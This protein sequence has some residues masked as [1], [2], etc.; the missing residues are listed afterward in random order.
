MAGGIVE[1]SC[2]RCGKAMS[3]RAGEATHLCLSC[4]ETNAV[5]AGATAPS[6]ARPPVT[7][8]SA[9]TPLRLASLAGGLLLI[10]AAAGYLVTTMIGSEAPAAPNEMPATADQPAGPMPPLGA[11][12]V[13]VPIDEPL[14]TFVGNAVTAAAKSRLVK[15]NRISLA[16]FELNHMTKEADIAKEAIKKDEEDIAVLRSAAGASA[17]ILTAGLAGD[18]ASFRQHLG[19]LADTEFG[20]N[21]VAQQLL[22][23]LDSIAAG[24]QGGRVPEIKQMMTIWDE[25]ISSSR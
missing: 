4:G 7:Q 17:S 2:S 3:A 8:H 5:P 1:Y 16:D 10:A 13:R 22:R 15:Y 6:A 23:S 12:P 9:A 20:Q 18:P 19:E 11:D 21:M 25:A 24:V 14:A